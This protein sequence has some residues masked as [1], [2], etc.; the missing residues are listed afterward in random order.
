M[1]AW[2]TKVQTTTLSALEGNIIN[3]LDPVVG[4]DPTK[5]APSIS[6][7]NTALGTL[8]TAVDTINDNLSN[9]KYSQTMLM[10]RV[11]TVD[12]YTVDDINQF[13]TIKLR[14]GFGNYIAI[15][16]VE[17][18]VAEFKTTSANMRMGLA[19]NNQSF[20]IYYNS[21]TSIKL[22]ECGTGFVSVIGIKYN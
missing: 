11:Y 7:V 15:D 19:Y 21:D 1:G 16:E 22:A 17:V 14:L 4:V 9:I 8:D 2:G 5:N 12:D 18:T 6:V 10:D 3:S 13:D 20:N